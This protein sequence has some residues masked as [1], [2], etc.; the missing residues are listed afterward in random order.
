MSW[1][2]LEADQSGQKC[3]LKSRDLEKAAYYVPH[4]E[5]ATVGGEARALGVPCGLGQ[6]MKKVWAGR[7]LQPNRQSDRQFSRS[8]HRRRR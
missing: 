4:H 1:D 3:W 8:L 7:K 6:G 5:A 2:Q